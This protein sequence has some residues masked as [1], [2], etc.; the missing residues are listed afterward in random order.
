MRSNLWFE[1]VFVFFLEKIIVSNNMRIFTI[2]YM[3]I[4][5]TKIK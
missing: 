1:I 3:L 2:G 4:V 5:I